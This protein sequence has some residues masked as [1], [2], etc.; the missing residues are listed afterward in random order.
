MGSNRVNVTK[1]EVHLWE[2]VTSIMVHLWERVFGGF[3]PWLPQS[4][5]AP[6]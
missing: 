5:A 1:D 2:R 3:H 6:H 4:G